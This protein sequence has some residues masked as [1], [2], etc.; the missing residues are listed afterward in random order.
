MKM[1]LIDEADNEAE[2]MSVLHYS[3]SFIITASFIIQ[4]ARSTA[5]GDSPHSVH[6]QRLAA[7]HI[8]NAHIP[9]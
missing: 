1:G 2:M 8:Y 7:R 6:P 3:F 4:V 9:N 5:K